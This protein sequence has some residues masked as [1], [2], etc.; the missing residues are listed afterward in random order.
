MSRTIATARRVLRQLGHDHRSVAMIL[1][2]PSVL[3]WVF[4]E[5]FAG[6]PGVFDRVGP[7]MLGVFPFTVMFLV[8][9]VTMVRE[10]T[11]GTL[12]RILAAPLRRLE[13]IGGY[14]LAF[15]L[16]A[17]AQA[18][19][20]AAVAIIGLGLDLD[21]PWVVVALAVLTAEV[22]TALGLLT[23]AFARTEF[24]AVQFM[25]VVVIPQVL[26]CGLLAPREDMAAAL[27]VVSGALPLSHATDAFAVAA[28]SGAPVT[29]M[30][31]DVV[32][33]AGFGIAAL[34]LAAL[35]LRR[36]TP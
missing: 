10:R 26:L 13:L 32:V 14:A 9:S 28:T 27:R 12:E 1:V 15:G 36:R 23:S 31:L 30:W 7:L 35:T 24:Q 33:V 25:P 16:A 4:S 3:L 34:V 6:A 5:V 20:T 11:S 8:T 29:D 17:F 22:G 19:I 2:V 18:V 21:S